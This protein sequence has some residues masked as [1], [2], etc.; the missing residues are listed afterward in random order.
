MINSKILIFIVEWIDETF[1]ILPNEFINFLKVF[2]RHWK[3]ENK[4]VILY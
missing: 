3:L 4:Y 2:N 1:Q